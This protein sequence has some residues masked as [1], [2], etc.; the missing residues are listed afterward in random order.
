M[1]KSLI[2][3]LIAYT[4]LASTQTIY[5]KDI[6]T[7]YGVHDPIDASLGGI[8][9]VFLLAS[10]LFVAGQVLIVNGKALK[11]RMDQ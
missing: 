10:G 6:P 5:A 9:W 4:T 2:T 1:K 8:E 3:G 7:V 11:K